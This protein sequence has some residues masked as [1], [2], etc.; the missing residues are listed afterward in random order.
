MF[1]K[2]LFIIRITHQ[3]LHLTRVVFHIDQH[4]RLFALVKYIIFIIFRPDHS[5][6]E[7]DRLAV[8]PRVLNKM[9]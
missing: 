2:N 4:L 9:S 8:L 3:V 7:I 5:P 1:I 6:L